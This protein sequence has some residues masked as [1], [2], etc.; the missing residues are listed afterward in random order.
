MWVE[1]MFEVFITVVVAH[2]REL[3]EPPKL[4]GL[5]FRV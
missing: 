5:G 3:N 2:L 1:G 4:G